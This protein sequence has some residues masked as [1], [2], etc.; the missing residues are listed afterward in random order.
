M[1]SGARVKPQYRGPQT[2]QCM[3]QSTTSQN[4]GVEKYC[5]GSL[6]SGRVL[7][8]P[9]MSS[10]SWHGY[11]CLLSHAEA[12]QTTVPSGGLL[13]SLSDH[14][15]QAGV[16]WESLLAVASVILHTSYLSSVELCQRR[17]VTNGKEEFFFLRHRSPCENGVGIT[18]PHR[19]LS[20]TWRWGMRVNHTESNSWGMIQAHSTETFF[21]K[22]GKWILKTWTSPGNVLKGGAP[23]S[24]ERVPISF[25]GHLWTIWDSVRIDSASIVKRS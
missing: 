17:R 19:Y 14:R 3:K 8:V 15:S 1:N 13:P 12:T 11:H 10:L 23:A 20:G 18:S 7:S 24:N 16:P 21:F 6:L 25:L 5:L 9:L 2:P 4:L 22:L